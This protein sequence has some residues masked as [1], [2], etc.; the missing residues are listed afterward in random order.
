MLGILL[1]LRLVA[2]VVQVVVGDQMPVLVELVE[3]QLQV[4]DTLVVQPQQHGLEVEVELVPLALRG[5]VVMQD[6]VVMV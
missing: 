5:V 4:K 2:L 3:L 1:R 6:E